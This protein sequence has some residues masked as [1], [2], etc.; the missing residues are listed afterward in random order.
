MS[1]LFQF[2]VKVSFGALYWIFY[3]PL[4]EGSY[5]FK[6]PE[7]LLTEERTVRHYATFSPSVSRCENVAAA[8]ISCPTRQF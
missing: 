8:G 6:R 5:V 1:L 4:F 3:V 7:R 2:V